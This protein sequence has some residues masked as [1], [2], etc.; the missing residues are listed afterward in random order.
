[1][2]SATTVALVAAVVFGIPHWFGTPGQIPGLLLAG[3]MGWFLTLS[4][5]Q[6]GGLGWAWTIHLVQ[7]VVIITLLMARERRAAPALAIPVTA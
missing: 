3:F 2:A 6:T 1:M 4:V 7:D 5:L